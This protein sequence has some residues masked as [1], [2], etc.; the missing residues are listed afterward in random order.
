MESNFYDK[1]I[2]FFSPTASLRRMKARFAQEFLSTTMKRK[3]EGAATGRRMDGWNSGGGTSANAEVKMGASSIR[4]RARDLCRNNAYATKGL[5]VI[6]NSV[7]GKGI[8]TQIMAPTND[9]DQKFTKL[10]Q[11]WAGSIRCDF[12][13]VNNYYQMQRLV[14]RTVAESGECLIRKRIPIEKTEIPLQLQILE[15][16]YLD[17]SRDGFKNNET[18]N[19]V[20][21]GIEIDAQGRRVAYWLFTDHPGETS[22]SLKS[23]FQSV[24]VPKEDILHVY[25]MDRPGQ[26]RGVSWFATV[27]VTLRDFDDYLDAQLLRQKIAACYS[28]FIQD[29]ETPELTAENQAKLI[30]ERLEPGGI[31]ILPPGKTISFANPPGVQN[32]QEYTSSVLRSISSGLGVTYEALTNDYSQVNF[33]SGR[34]G[35]LEFQRNVDAWR[36]LL[37]VPQFCKPGFQ[38]FLESA[39]LVG[40]SAQGVTAKWTAP[41]RE[42]ID[43]VSEVNALNQ[44]V[45]SGFVTLSEAIRQSGS[46]P[47]DHLNEIQSDNAK[48]D[49]KGIL[50]DCDPRAMTKAGFNQDV[51]EKDAASNP[52]VV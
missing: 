46:D 6:V 7:I 20:W 37:L 9:V 21:Q 16:D 33:S 52:A 4:E 22:R 42:M 45:R 14:L 49:E 36:W 51:F 29:I 11:D 38:W 3:Y 28:V 18:G 48:L 27:I 47:E 32:F 26:L 1:I 50:L 13:G 10:F 35:W 30:G 23:S 25:K 39:S 41:R 34:M 40:A 15:P 24:R 5:D 12:D 43:P 8:Y 2:G 31:E 17:T 44:A 19:E